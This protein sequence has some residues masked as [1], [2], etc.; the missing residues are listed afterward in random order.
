ME[1][2]KGLNSTSDFLFQEINKLCLEKV[3]AIKPNIKEFSLQEDF[4]YLCQN[5][6]DFVQVFYYDKT[7]ED[8]KTV[9]SRLNVHRNK[10]LEL[11]ASM[12][13]YN[14]Q[15]ELAVNQVLLELRKIVLIDERAYRYQNTVGVSL[16]FCKM[17]FLSG[18]VDVDDYLSQIV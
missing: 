10:S 11:Q 18:T 7:K 1:H 4:F 3:E 12:L 14:L 16:G 15:L 5:K 6:V 8:C 17:A 2:L 13:N 9:A